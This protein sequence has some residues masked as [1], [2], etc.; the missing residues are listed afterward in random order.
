MTKNKK[1]YPE[2]SLYF[3]FKKTDRIR[4]APFKTN[5]PNCGKVN[6]EDF[7][8]ENFEPMKIRHILHCHRCGH[9][10]QEDGFFIL[11][12]KRVPT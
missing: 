11:Q 8:A 2:R 6:V 9:N 7:L 1:K 10:S 4:Y 12:W 5:C 3:N